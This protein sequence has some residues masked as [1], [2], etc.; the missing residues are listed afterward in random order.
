MREMLTSFA[1][2]A[3]LTAA[4]AVAQTQPQ[5]QAQSPVAKVSY[6]DK[7]V[8]ENELEIG[9]RLASHKICHTH[10]EWGQMRRDDRSATERTQTQRTMDANGH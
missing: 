8:C 3:I 6:A 9:S 7:V 1:V 10:S 2:I 5:L 4:P